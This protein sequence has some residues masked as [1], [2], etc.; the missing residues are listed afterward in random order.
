[1]KHTHSSLL[2][3]VAQSQALMLTFKTLQQHLQCCTSVKLTS[4]NL[5]MQHSACAVFIEE[6]LEAR[7]S[8]QTHSEEGSI[9]LVHTQQHMESVQQM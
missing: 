5:Q 1:M 7:P 2:P 3:F 8:Q 4:S 9:L 6:K